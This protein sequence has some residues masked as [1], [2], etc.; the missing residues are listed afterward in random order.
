[1]ARRC[2][3]DRHSPHMRPGLVAGRRGVLV[4]RLRCRLVRRQ[5][6]H[7][8]GAGGLL[9]PRPLRCGLGRDGPRHDH[10]SALLRSGL[11]R[12]SCGAA[13]ALAASRN[14]LPCPSRR[15]RRQAQSLYA[16]INP[17]SIHGSGSMLDVPHDSLPSSLREIAFQQSWWRRRICMSNWTF[18]KPAW[19][20][21]MMTGNAPEQPVTGAGWTPGRRPG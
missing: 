3:G 13:A 5:S 16:K 1:M 6:G 2:S 19:H 14:G 7:R 9:R 20:A 17:F 4:L 11:A 10:D 18:G 15:H 12:A 8:R 21:G